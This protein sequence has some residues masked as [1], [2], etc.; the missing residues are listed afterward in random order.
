MRPIPVESRGLFVPEDV[1]AALAPILGRALR[2]ARRN[3]ATV[4]PDVVE[5]IERLGV[6]GNRHRGVVHVADHVA[7]VD[8]LSCDDFDSISVKQAANSLEVS[9]SAV[10]GSL[11]RG[12]LH[13]E[14]VGRAWRVCALDVDAR[15]R[16]ER[17]PH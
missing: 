7:T 15:Q 2:D 6:L 9:G 10:T 16:G 13:G 14:K 5:T 8:S 11:R 4:H 17:C 3:G 1:A 12:S